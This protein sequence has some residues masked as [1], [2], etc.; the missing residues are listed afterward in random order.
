MK[1]F[2][3]ILSVLFFSANTFSQNG[4]VKGVAFDTSINQAVPNATITIL[5]K[6]DSSLVSFGMADNNGKFDLSEIPN[7]EYRLL[8]TQV[9][10]RSAAKVFTIDNEHKN[11]DLGN[12]AMNDKNKVL[13]E[14]VVE[15]PPVTMIGDTIQYNA[16][17]FKTQP[18][19][20][21]EDLLKKLPGVK[22]DK[23]GTLKAQGEKVQ[24]VLVDGKEFF[25][26]DPKMATKNLP[27][28]AIDKVQ[29]YDKLSEQ[30][31]MTGFDDGNSEK[32]IN[33][34]LKKDKKKGAFGK[35]NAGAG[36][37]DRY[38]GKFNVNSFKGAR[39]MS[40]IGMGNNTNAEG[41]SFMDILN[42]TGAMN[43]LKNGGGNIN[44]SIS[45][46]DPLAGL[47]GGN[48]SGIN[49]TWGGGINYN[50]IIGTKT[51]FQSNYFYSR[52]N[53]VR[54]SNIQRQYFLPANLY[55]Q[56]SYSNNLN[57][58]HR[59]NFSADFQIDSF[60]SLKVAPNFTYQ[61]TTNR[62]TSDYNTFSEQGVKINEGNSNNIANNEATSLSTNILFRNKFR[63]K[64]RTFSVNL[65]TNFNNS[66][67]DGSLQSFTNY[68]NS[69]GSL[70]RNDSIN[71]KNNN[72]A[73]LKGYNARAVYTEP[74]FKRSLLEFSVS[75]SYTK[76]ISS[77]TTYDFNGSNGKFDLLNRTLTNDFENTY[78]FTNAGLRIRKQTRQ[79]N[80]AIGASWQQAKLEGTV[81]SLG[82]D[83]V[84]SK[85][86]TNILPNARFQYY[87]TRYKSIT[88]NYSTNTSQ[89]TVAQ[90]QP[91]PDNSNPLYIKLGN[92]NLKQEFTQS[93]RLNAQLVNPF[94]NRNLFAFFSLQQ[95]QNKIVNFDKINS[96]GVDS[97]L[98]VNV[99]G[100]YNMNGNISFS[101][102]VHFL[103]G[104]LDISSVVN[105]YH[106]KQFA[107]APGG[108]VQENTINTFTLG[109]EARL[110]M[111]P[112]DKLNLS[113]TASLNH[114][115]TTYSLA[116]S[117]SSKYFTQ[118]YGVDLDWQFAKGFLL[119]T[120]FNYRNNNQYATDF[121]TKV[122]LWNA[123]ISKQVLH[124]NRGEL[125]LSV[126]DI[127][128]QNI[129]INRSANQNY[130]EDSRVNTLGRF[131]LLSFTYNL[132]KTGLN[133][134]G[135]GGG[136]RLMR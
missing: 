75:N 49:T 62:N 88:L 110:G 117:R 123:S 42:F 6:K 136:I 114:S 37:D 54:I 97:V 43:Q 41:F 91:L 50:D 25:G 64:G 89:P 108:I 32:T 33:L 14:V 99:N 12:I 115:N 76:N 39:Q 36:T 93:L 28:D 18:N 80:Y 106:G 16:G 128:N 98:P 105:A 111:S 30:A 107:N 51:D 40:V 35:V 85:S 15:A 81:T 100:V 72:G 13:D 74:L 135:N 58:N 20:S 94:K 1:Q 71:Q 102:P 66:D 70:F 21:V 87:F 96:L 103:K 57:N 131:F 29:V 56:N 3:T 129:G 69:T 45:Q 2:I 134:A 77:K 22:V 127:L 125:K 52:Y 63:K 120:D 60:R 119:A 9:N 82:K 112:T 48:N 26:N 84:I 68:Y 23:D 121:N 24:K 31:Q 55:K 132:T 118:E 73:N 133:N 34:K 90:L 38:Q 27:A 116:S 104:S 17:S 8:L 11:I 7:G 122:S 47:L 65:L 79:Y 113:L 86:F 95:T 101:F 92:P 19:A 10:Y 83:S 46:D 124:F 67:G 5:K 53:P 61:K 126:K 78:G 109:P 59:L 130:I 4:S 44:L